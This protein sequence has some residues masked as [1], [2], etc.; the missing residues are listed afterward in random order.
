MTALLALVA[1]SSLFAADS[2]LLDQAWEESYEGNDAIHRHY[3]D[4]FASS[5]DIHIEE[6][7]RYVADDAIVSEPV[8]DLERAGARVYDRFG[9]I[10]G[11]VEHSCA[12]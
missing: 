2:T 12:I 5:P 6:R 9:W 8:R 3:L 7:A 11:C 10:C 1:A 4:E